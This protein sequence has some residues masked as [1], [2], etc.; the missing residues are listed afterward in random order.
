MSKLKAVVVLAAL[1]LLSGCI[2]VPH[3]HGNDRDG[4][5]DRY[6]HDDRY[7]HHDDRDYR[8]DRR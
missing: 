4:R 6:D 8:R 5:H 3:H 7:H 2:V 1:A